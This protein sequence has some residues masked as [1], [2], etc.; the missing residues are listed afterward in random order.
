MTECMVGGFLGIF[1]F[2]AMSCVPK[3]LAMYNQAREERIKEQLRPEM[4]EQAKREYIRD[5]ALSIGSARRQRILAG[6]E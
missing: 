1:A 5:R 3:V 4:L 2:W 6:E